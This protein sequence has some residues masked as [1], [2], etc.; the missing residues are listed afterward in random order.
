[1]DPAAPDGFSF[2]FVNLWVDFGGDAGEGEGR[3]QGV[4]DDVRVANHLGVGAVLQADGVFERAEFVVE[5][6]EQGW[7]GA[8]AAGQSGCL[9][10][11][12]RWVCLCSPSPD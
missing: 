2:D 4:H 1:M 12:D 5:V 6:V 11:R 7:Q 3:C 10:R 9:P 8:P